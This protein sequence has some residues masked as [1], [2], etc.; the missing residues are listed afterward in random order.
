MMVTLVCSLKY[1][2]FSFLLPSFQLKAKV[3][4]RSMAECMLVPHWK[5]VESFYTFSFVSYF[6]KHSSESSMAL[7]RTDT[8]NTLKFP[9]L[10]GNGNCFLTH[11]FV[12][13]NSHL[14]NSWLINIFYSPST[15]QLDHC[16]SRSHYGFRGSFYIYHENTSSILFFFFAF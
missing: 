12:L 4:M 9:F 15:E 10:S 14:Q 11:I 6:L 13:S 5:F 8:L 2:N 16:Q 7:K 3:T 1:L